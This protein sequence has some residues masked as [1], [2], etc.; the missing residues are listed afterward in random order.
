MKKE[1]KATSAGR[2]NYLDDWQQGRRQETEGQRRLPFL[3]VYRIFFRRTTPAPR[4]YWICTYRLLLVEPGLAADGLH[5]DNSL[6]YSD[7]LQVDG[8]E[9]LKRLVRS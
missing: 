5:N 2:E 4:G 6:Q 3:Q 1:E 7:M 9:G 8:E